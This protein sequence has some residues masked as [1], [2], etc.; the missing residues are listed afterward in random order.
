MLGKLKNRGFH[1]VHVKQLA[2]AVGTLQ[3]LRPAT[4]PLIAIMTCSLYFTIAT[5]AS[6]N[7]YISMYALSQK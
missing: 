1:V 2:K 6:W 7:S 3:S 4:G 5:A